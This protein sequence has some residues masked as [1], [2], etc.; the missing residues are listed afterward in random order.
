MEDGSHEWD[1]LSSSERMQRLER[2][3]EDALAA[4]KAG[5][6]PGENVVVAQAALTSMRAEL[7]GTPSG[8]AKHRSYELSLSHSLGGTL[9]NEGEQGEWAL[10]RVTDR[11]RA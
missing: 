4:I 1:E 2:S 6:P 7:Y 9:P 8:R 5:G 11:D 10:E 3:F